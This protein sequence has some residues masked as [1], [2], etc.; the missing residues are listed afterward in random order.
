MATTLKPGMR[1]P[2]FFGR[3]APQDGA[4]AVA[5]TTGGIVVARGRSRGSGSRRR[6]RRA[7][8]SGR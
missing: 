2:G 3:R 1:S 7:D 5:E 8:R 4:A 6:S